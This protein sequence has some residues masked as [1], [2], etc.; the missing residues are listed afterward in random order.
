MCPDNKQGYERY[1]HNRTV[2]NRAIGG[3]AEWLVAIGTMNNTCLLSYS[4][5]VHA[6]TC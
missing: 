6:D 5:L 1:T 4:R 2:F 3:P